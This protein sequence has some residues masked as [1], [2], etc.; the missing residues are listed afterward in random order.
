ME[1]IITSDFMVEKAGMI[2]FYQ[3]TLSHNQDDSS[4]HRHCYVNLK[5]HSQASN[6][7]S[8]SSSVVRIAG[9]PICFLI[10]KTKIIV[11][12]NQ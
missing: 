8:I 2:I 7:T 4:L 5:Y 9:R 1:E 11:A 6:N 3:S 12:N 10:F